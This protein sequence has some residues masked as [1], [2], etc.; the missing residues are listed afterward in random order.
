MIAL[1]R[2]LVT[3]ELVLVILDLEAAIA[4]AEILVLALM[5]EQRTAQ[6]ATVIVLLDLLMIFANLSLVQVIVLDMVPVITELAFAIPPLPEAF[7]NA[8]TLE[9]AEM[10]EQRTVQLDT[11]NAL[12]AL[13]ETFVNL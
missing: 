2:V 10:V 11:V 7:V 12:K 6:L 4:L 5:E 8:E 13:M 1:D 3:T 9:T